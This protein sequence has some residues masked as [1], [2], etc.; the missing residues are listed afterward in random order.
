MNV[1]D[2]AATSAPLIALQDVSMEFPGRHADSLKS[3][4]L[5]RQDDS[6]SPKVAI[7]SATLR[8]TAGDRVA[9]VGL[10]GA[11]K[12]TLLRV[13]AGILPPTTGRVTCVGRRSTILGDG[14]GFDLEQTG[15]D[16]IFTQLLARGLDRDE[17]R[18]SREEV[19]DF[20]Q[21]GQVL[22]APMKTYSSGMVLRIAFGVAT[23][24]SPE[25]LLIDEVI[26]AGDHRFSR[27]ADARLRRYLEAPAVMVLA[28]HNEQI[29]RQFC[30]TAIWLDQGQIVATGEVTEVLS[31]YHRGDL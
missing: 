26:G 12:S 14:V 7:Q 15:W 25:I 5:R 22:F 10:N 11:G 9:L 6:G 20:T 28:S 18:R 27:Q 31:R 13:M 2:G 30:T 24:G 21:L 4:L 8:L 19:A 16:N 3:R 17:A 29:L 23:S 1:G